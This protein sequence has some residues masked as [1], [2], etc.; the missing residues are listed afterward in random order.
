MKKIKK[1]LAIFLEFTKTFDSVNY[2]I[3]INL[4]LLFGTKNSCL[5][6]FKSYLQNKKQKVKINE[7]TGK[8]MPIDCNVLQG[9]VLGSTLFILYINKMYKLVNKQIVT[10]VY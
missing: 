2:F 8:Y 10:Y 1:T 3:L 5:D 4:F 9:S 7:V 6:W